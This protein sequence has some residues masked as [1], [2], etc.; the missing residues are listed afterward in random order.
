[1]MRRKVTPAV[2]TAKRW[3]AGLYGVAT[4]FRNGLL[5]PVKHPR[6]I[7][8][9]ALA[10]ATLARPAPHQ[11]ISRLVYQR[12]LFETSVYGL[13]ILGGQRHLLI[14]LAQLLVHEGEGVVA[15]RQ[16]LNGVLAVRA[17]DRV[18]RV[19][20]HV[21][22]HLH[23]RVLVALYRQHDFFAGE[24]LLQW[25]GLRR[26][27]LVPLAVILGRGM[28]VVGRGIVVFD[29][30]VLTRYHP[31]HMRMVPAAALIQCD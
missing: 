30:D 15:R 25:S 26:L 2:K 21:D 11:Q 1:M 16:A 18:E 22:V 29:F 13:A 12:L 4:A 9:R 19:L 17:G 6:G 3:S 31:Q 24:A 14:L 7:P 10:R 28:D 23:P 8:G 27:G 5:D 20:H